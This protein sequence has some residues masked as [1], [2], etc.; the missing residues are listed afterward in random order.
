M[1]DV[2][3]RLFHEFAVTMAVAILISAAVSLTLTPMLCA[4][5]LG[6]ESLHSTGR[7]GRW[8]E[9]SLERLIEAYGRGLRHVMDH[10]TATLILFAATL[11]A[12]AGLYVLVPKGF[13]PVQDTGVIQ[14]VTEA[15]QSSSFQAMAE[16]QQQLAERLLEDRAVDRLTSFIGV[17]GSNATLNT[18][19]MLITLKPRELRSGETITEITR[20]LTDNAARIPGITLYLQPVQELTIEERA[21][22]TPYQLLLSSPDQQTLS[23]TAQ[24][25]VTRMNDL[26]QLSDVASDLLDRGLRAHIEIDRAAAARLGVTVAA[27]SNTLYNAFGQR[28]V[29]TLFTQS[30]QYRVVL[31]IAPQFRQGLDALGTLFV[32]SSSGAQIPLSALARVTERPGMLAIQHVGQF[33]A[34]SISFNT[35]PGVSLG[36]AVKAI[37]T[38][39]AELDWPIAVDARFQGAALAFQG[40]LRDT[41]LLILAAVVAMYIVLGILYESFIH[42]ITILSTLPSAALGALLALLAWPADLDLIAVIGIILLIGIVKKNGIMMVDFALAAQRERG[43]TAKEAIHQAAVLRF[44]PILMTTLAAVV[45]ALPLMLGSGWGS[46]LRQPLGVTLV[47]GLVVSQLLTLYTTP[48]IY[49]RFARLARIGP[50]SEA[51]RA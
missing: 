3:G 40:S 16:R 21:T 19:R 39:R 32:P 12:T 34:V 48:V 30:N 18:G 27:V 50:A 45:G 8:I 4:R 7:L 51:A 44:R 17:D 49:L 1:R 46:E 43:L 9:R 5:W 36:A 29:S 37:E 24:M 10:G 11:A 38:M 26:P 23:D 13:F 20:R 47:G 28:L 25:L 15:T 35:A 22:R 33:P 31:E 14:V 42:P 2:V 6:R 41:L